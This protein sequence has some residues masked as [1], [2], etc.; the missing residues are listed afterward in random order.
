MSD[1]PRILDLFCGAGGAATGLKRAGFSPY[2]VDNKPEPRYPF[3]FLLMDALEAMDRLLRGEGLTFNNGETLYLADFD[4]Y[5]ASPPCQHASTIAKQIRS[6]RPDT[7]DHPNLIPATRER[8]IESGVPYIIE[9]V[10]GAELVS[11]VQLCGSWFGL[12]LRRHRLFE[13]SFA[14][15]STPCCHHWQKP[16]FRSLDKRRGDALATV[17]GVHGHINYSGESEL[18]KEAMGID[19]MNDYEL[20]Q[21]VPPAYSEYI[22]RQLLKV[23]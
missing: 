17:V 11:P 1:R 5:W 14:A 2:G 13:C 19:W 3:P 22:G 21:A 7:Y 6:M 9:N 15:A 16:R 23:L 4:A 8:L 10:V 18:R 20:T 12:N